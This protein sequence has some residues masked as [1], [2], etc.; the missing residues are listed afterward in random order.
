MFD[1]ANAISYDGLMVYGTPE[2]EVESPL[3]ESAWIDVSSQGARGHWVPAQGEAALELVMALLD[4]RRKHGVE[5]PLPLAVITP[6][7]EVRRGFGALLKH[8]LS[9]TARKRRLLRFGTVHTF[10]GKEDEH[11]I[12]LLGGDPESSGAQ[13]WAA[14]PPNLVNVA[15]TRARNRLYVIGDRKL[16]VRQHVLREV[17][18][19]LERLTLEQ[20]RTRGHGARRDCAIDGNGERVSAR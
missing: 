11:V 6:F 5:G 4:W 16:W 14:H 20:W 18:Q 17:A 10:Q 1:I 13:A 15:V 2:R 7:R 8:H 12:L 19:R 9:G 3:G